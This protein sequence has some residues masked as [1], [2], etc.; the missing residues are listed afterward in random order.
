M[1]GRGGGSQFGGGI[2]EDGRKYFQGGIDTIGICAVCYDSVNE[3]NV[4]PNTGVVEKINTG[5]KQLLTICRGCFGNFLS[6]NTTGNINYSQKI[7]H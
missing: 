4:M 6:V 1:G 5:G 2:K 7:K 3:A